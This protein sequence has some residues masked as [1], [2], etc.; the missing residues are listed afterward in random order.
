MLS[1]KKI[2]FIGYAVSTKALE[3]GGG[4]DNKCYLGNE[5]ERADMDARLALLKLAAQKAQKAFA[6]DPDVLKVFVIPEFFFRGAYGAYSGAQGEAYLKEK[7]RRLKNEHPALDMALWGTSL[8][9]A[10]KADYSDPVIQ[11]AACLGDDYLSLY[12][13][14][15]DYRN[16]VGKETPTLKSML[17]FLDELEA[18]EDDNAVPKDL[19]AQDPLFWVIKDL[20][21]GCDKT[22]PVTVSNKAQVMLEGDGYLTVQKRFKSK[23]DFVLNHY[24]DEA[25]TLENHAAY[26]QTFVRY[27]PIASAANEEKRDPLDQYSVFDW[28]G[29]KVGVEICLD[30]VRERLR[31]AGGGLDLHLIPSCG[32]EVMPGAVAARAG[33]YV[34]NC[35]GDYTLD[36]A[37]NGLGAHSQLFRVEEAGDAP[38]GKNAKLGKRIE[39]EQVIKIDWQEADR[40]YSEGAG[41]LHIYPPQP[42]N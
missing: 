7:L 3:C 21:A 11:K 5:D 40:Y 26:L 42:L 8:F 34:F 22:A 19:P 10:Q 9:A 2:Q 38:S 37:C 16:L 32:V 13:A 25:R 14:C 41:Q 4:G 29:L 27:P 18:W 31:R 20:L 23:V 33:G 1:H 35:D 36:D 30:H 39:P 6:P 12:R 17:F 24:R 28:H 15:R